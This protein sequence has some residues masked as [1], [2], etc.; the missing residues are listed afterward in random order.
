MIEISKKKINIKT[1]QK[2]NKKITIYG[3]ILLILLASLLT[4]L[5][6]LNKCINKRQENITKSLEAYNKMYLNYS[7]ISI[8]SELAIVLKQPKVNLDFKT[9]WENNNGYTLKFHT[10]YDLMY[11]E[12][13][14]TE[15]D[16]SIIQSWCDE[17]FDKGIE[18]IKVVSK[19]IYC[20][21]SDNPELIPYDSL[22]T[23]DCRTM[24]VN[25]TDK[26]LEAIQRALYYKE[27]K[28]FQFNG[29]ELLVTP[30]LGASYDSLSNLDSYYYTMCVVRLLSDF[31]V[32]NQ[33]KDLMSD[34][35]TIINYRGEL[36]N[37]EV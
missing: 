21:C 33:F 16:M 1:I 37:A 10:M 18:C 34:Y 15:T 4:F 22:L 7:E 25:D 28:M 29:T 11:C 23:Y 36:G 32:S 5:W 12:L 20:C 17:L 13:N 30:K 19:T 14:T 3:A 35:N 26:M 24:T 31:N 2:F 8:D 6:F 27:F 9:E